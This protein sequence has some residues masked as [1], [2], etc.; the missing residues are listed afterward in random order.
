MDNQNI[1]Y[2]VGD[3]VVHWSYG[4]GVIVQ[5]DEKELSGR[6]N[7]YYVVQ[8]RDLMLWVPINETGECS[9]RSP[10]PRTDFQKMFRILGSPGEPLSTDRFARKTQLTLL[11]KDGTLESICRVIRDL[12]SY[13]REKKMNDYDGAIL[14]R[15]SNFL[16][17]E[18][19]LALDLPA[20]QVEQELKE[21]LNG[22]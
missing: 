1:V 6:T 4:S 14:E 13:R 3:Q 18:W 22:T 11:L 21:L 15:A 10:T 20:H 9:L 7:Q 12:V 8:T 5:L 16:V 17:D 2:Q 19:S